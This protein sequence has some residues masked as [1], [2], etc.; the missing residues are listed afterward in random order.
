[1]TA[2][3]LPADPSVRANIRLCAGEDADSAKACGVRSTPGL[4]FGE[5]NLCLDAKAMHWLLTQPRIQL[6]QPFYGR[7]YQYHVPLTAGPSKLQ[8]LR[9][10]WHCH[11]ASTVQPDLP[12]LPTHYHINALMSLAAVA[13]WSSLSVSFN[14]FEI[15]VCPMFPSSAM[16]SSMAL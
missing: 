11:H 14:A 4:P 12:C 16:P 3:V 9:F 1:M 2:W 10:T 7:R 6:Q 5:K 15:G 8:Q 13:L